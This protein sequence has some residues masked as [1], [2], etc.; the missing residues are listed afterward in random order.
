MRMTA[1]QM[2]D[3]VK[4]LVVATLEM[5]EIEQKINISDANRV[6]NILS[7]AT[8]QLRDGFRGMDDAFETM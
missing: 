2:L 8:T 5:V 7:E 1:E 4:D 6:N 3:L